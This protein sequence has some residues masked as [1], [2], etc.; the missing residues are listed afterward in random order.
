MPVTRREFI[1]GL[2]AIT[3]IRFLQPIVVRAGEGLGET[4]PDPAV[5][6]ANRL[7]VVF[8]QGGND[9]LNTVIPWGEA[10]N[11]G[12]GSY[13]VYAQVRP[14]LKYTPDDT[15]GRHLALTSGDDAKRLALNPNMPY[16][17]SLY[18]GGR[19]AV[20]Q[21]VD[22]PNH[23]YSHFVSTDI[24]E[25][26][27]PG[28]APTSGWIGRHLDRRAPGPGEL[29]GLGIGT[30][31][32]LILRG[33]EHQG[34]EV[35]SIRDTRF[36][37]GGSTN[38]IADA[39]HAAFSRYADH[40]VYGERP[41]PLRA[42]VG[43]QAAGAV[44]LV[45]QLETVPAPPNTSNR[46]AN[47]LLTARTLLEQ[48][49][50]VECVFV[51]H[52]GGYDTHSNQ[53]STHE[54]LLTDLDR[55]LEAFYLGTLGGQQTGAGAIDPDLAARTLVV[56]TSEFARRIGENGTPQSAGTDHGAAGPVFMVGPPPADNQAGVRLVPG[57]HG[58]HPN[59]GTPLAPADNLEKTTEL[60]SVYQ[61]VLQS[62]LADP[63]GPYDPYGPVPGLFVS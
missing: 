47:A 16:L 26:G 21:G 25:S 15:A 22:Y 11:E 30:E 32:P 49:L 19:V 23:S 54:R 28:Q 29:K 39:R 3:G 58:R 48:P 37:D 40:D 33:D 14:T 60:R 17:Y 35:T 1:A 6:Q 4:L 51:T 56:T 36:A 10:Q 13:A 20:V 50:G 7:V 9:G 44:A 63:E 8:Q 43:S 38:A 59:M 18:T 2:G 31:L 53:F 46:L 55:A 52:A 42:F 24:W 61:S 27:Q 34:V 45:R 41:E 12:G 5:Q 62:W 57:I